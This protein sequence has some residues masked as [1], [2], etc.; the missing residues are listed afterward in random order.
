MFPNGRLADLRRETL[1]R[2]GE[3]VR[4]CPTKSISMK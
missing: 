2:C 4:A 3:C 1:A